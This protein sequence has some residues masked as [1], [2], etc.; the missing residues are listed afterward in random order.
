M[1]SRFCLANHREIALAPAHEEIHRMLGGGQRAGA[2]PHK[3]QPFDSGQQKGGTGRVSPTVAERHEQPAAEPAA[4]GEE[5]AAAAEQ[6]HRRRRPASDAEGPAP[7]RLLTCPIFYRTICYATRILHV[8]FKHSLQEVSS[9]Y[10]SNIIV[11]SL[12][13]ELLRYL[14]KGV[15]RPLFLPE[16]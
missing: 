6:A 13:L 15:N 11:D 10:G 7:T 1:V 9:N 4:G 8:R 12:A 16:A 3:R 14:K 5:P 2:S